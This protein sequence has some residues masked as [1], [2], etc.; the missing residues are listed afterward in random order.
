MFIRIEPY[1]PGVSPGIAAKTICLLLI[2]FQISVK[3]LHD[4][5]I[6][7]RPYRAVPF[8]PATAASALI[9]LLPGNNTP[10]LQD[11]APV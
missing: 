6:I 5:R 2:A 10:L 8:V 1:L 4:P 9:G 3:Q 11:D 7:L